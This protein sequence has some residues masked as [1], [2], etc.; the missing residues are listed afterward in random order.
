MSCIRR[1][2]LAMI[3]KRIVE[4]HR[5]HRSGFPDLTLWDPATSRVALIEVKGPG[6]KLSTKQR[7]WLDFFTK[8][9]M[10]A[11]VCHVT[12]ECNDWITSYLAQP[13]RESS[14]PYSFKESS[15]SKRSRDKENG[16]TKA[17]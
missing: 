16:Q 15:N 9:G 7:L 4:D 1:E 13:K 5:H 2:Q 17:N 6:D 14:P 3:I 12:G 10:D 8:H 11:F